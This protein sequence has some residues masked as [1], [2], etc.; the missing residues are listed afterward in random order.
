MELEIETGSMSLILNNKSNNLDDVMNKK[1]QMISEY[2]EKYEPSERLNYLSV[3]YIKLKISFILIE[4]GN[5]FIIYGEI[6]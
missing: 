5:S 2:I 4:N 1:S 3:E 6:L